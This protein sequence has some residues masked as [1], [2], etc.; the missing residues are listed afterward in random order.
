M[1]TLSYLFTK[2]LPAQGVPEST[3]AG[4]VQGS[5]YVW[6]GE[7]RGPGRPTHPDPGKHLSMKLPFSLSDV[8]QHIRA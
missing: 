5:K 2:D 8:C 6:W 3:P 7:H 1:E 4:D